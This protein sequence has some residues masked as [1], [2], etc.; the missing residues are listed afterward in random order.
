MQV[1]MQ[2]NS[3]R[4]APRSEYTRPNQLSFS[5]FE[6]PFY[7]QLNPT[8]RWVV[9]SSQIPWDDLVGL[10]NKR[11]SPKQTGRPSSIPVY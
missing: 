3:K 9:V 5:G 1:I 8:N 10:F 11:I 4:R 7:N 2:K 6:A